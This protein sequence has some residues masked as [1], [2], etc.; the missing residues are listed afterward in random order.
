MTPDLQFECWGLKGSNEQHPTSLFRFR[1]NEGKER[2]GGTGEGKR[3]AGL[4]HM[5][6][7]ML[8]SLQIQLFGRPGFEVGFVELADV[9][10]FPLQPSLWVGAGLSLPG[11][12][13]HMAESDLCREA[14][15]EKALRAQFFHTDP[16]DESLLWSLGGG[17]GER[18]GARNDALIQ[19]FSVSALLT[20][21]A[22]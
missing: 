8:P 22:G 10:A 12:A 13:Q 7:K 11:Q 15:P 19:G 4:R 21:W 6:I 3:E 17:S 20:F 2:W 1:T 14:G 18:R 5:E 16:S 9:P